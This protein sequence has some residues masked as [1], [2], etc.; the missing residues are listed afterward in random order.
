[1]AGDVYQLVA[2]LQLKS[3]Q[4]EKQIDELR[5]K[6]DGL[7]K[8]MEKQFKGVQKP[9]KDLRKQTTAFRGDLLSLGLGMQFVTGFFKGFINDA[10]NATG[11]SDIFGET[12]QTVVRPAVMELIDPSLDLLDA[13]QQLEPDTQL[14]IGRFTLWGTAIG[15]LIGDIAFL[16]LAIEMG[17]IPLMARWG[18]TAGTLFGTGAA[19]AA[20][21]GIV[22][23][24]YGALT[25]L[26]YW[27]D[28][29]LIS[30][31]NFGKGGVM[32]LESIAKVGT[33]PFDAIKISLDSMYKAAT[34][35]P[36][37]I[38]MIGE[39][40]YKL[41]TVGKITREEEKPSY[42]KIAKAAKME[43][44]LLKKI[45]GLSLPQMSSK[46][47]INEAVNSLYG[48]SIARYPS[49][50]LKTDNRVFNNNVTINAEVAK[51][52]LWNSVQTEMDRQMR[53]TRAQFMS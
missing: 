50:T 13:I 6:V 35:I 15:S 49:S 32:A 48:K 4:F 31:Q 7:T 14:M 52:H 39:S 30:F 44:P 9:I 47:P 29:D 26:K 17:I 19:L 5:K 33:H 2:E 11:V 8:R 46:N 24:L 38:G 25:T 51:S 37:A 34:N 40:I 21:A 42:E 10:L 45:S 53:D 20:G 12:M 27:L 28:E 41:F 1:M 43:S 36:E 22:T 3:V 16:A 18:I 23:G